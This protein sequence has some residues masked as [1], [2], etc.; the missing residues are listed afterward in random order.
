MG[1]IKI[2]SELKLL[3]TSFQNPKFNKRCL[4]LDGMNKRGQY[5]LVAAIVFIGLFFSI[6]YISNSSSEKTT[7]SRIYELSREL[8]IE[9]SKS[10]EYY[11]NTDDNQMENFTREFSEYS[12]KDVNIYFIRG[13]TSS[14]EVYN[15]TN[16]VKNPIAFTQSDSTVNTTI[17]G[18][19]Y[20]FEFKKGENFYFVIARNTDEERYVLK[21]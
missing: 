7:S 5:Y 6:V 14:P 17:E 21:G 16:S 15:Y 12:G 4:L 11:S 20:A 8:K 19:S 3:R 2:C 10:L 9:S 18:K 1:E 13:N